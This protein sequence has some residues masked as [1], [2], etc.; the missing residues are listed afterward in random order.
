MDFNDS[1]FKDI[2]GHSYAVDKRMEHMVPSVK[3][4]FNDEDVEEDFVSCIKI[5]A[6]L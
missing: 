6:C 2:N 4:F 5:L 1:L 3:R